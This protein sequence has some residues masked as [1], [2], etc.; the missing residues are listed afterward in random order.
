MLASGLEV[1]TALALGVIGCAG[2]AVAM[3]LRAGPGRIMRQ[4]A[5]PPPAVSQAAEQ[6]VFLFEAGALLDAT[7]KARALLSAGDARTPEQ[8][9]LLTLLAPL[10]PDLPERFHDTAG[11]ARLRAVEGAAAS[12]LPLSAAEVEHLDGRVRLT[13]VDTLPDAPDH[14]LT[15][16]ALRDEMGVLARM[17]AD[18]QCLVWCETPSGSI[19]WANAAYLAF[20]DAWEAT[21]PAG[22]DAPTWP[23]A[24][25]FPPLSGSGPD[26]AAVAAPEVKR[27]L[28]VTDAAGRITGWFDVRSVRRGFETMH[29][30]T[31]ARA[32][33][34][35]EEQGRMFVQT[36]TETFA[37]LSIGLA[38]FD[39]ERRLSTF[40]PALLDLTRLPMTF[41]SGRPTLA[42]TL[43]KLREV[44]VLQE[45]R[46]YR[47]WKRDITALVDA[48]REGTY[49]ETWT[50]A[51]GQTYRVTGRPH[52][53]GAIAFL[54]EDISAEVS[55]TRAF[56]AEIGTAQAVLD[57]LD[58]A[59]AV[60][61]P[62]GT[63][64][65]C[66][67]RF[68]AIWLPGGDAGRIEPVTLAQVVPLWQ[69]RAAPT[70]FWAR[71]RGFVAGSEGR[72]T[73]TET[74]RLTDGRA[75]ICRLTPLPGGATL[76]AFADG[77][78]AEVPLSGIGA[79][80]TKA[81]I[82]KRLASALP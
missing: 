18:T 28:K 46:D 63:L 67:A 12:A 73:L 80:E 66:N 31:D 59:I 25:V 65:T 1:W 5:A 24:T 75:A 77:T 21:E 22:D 76:V 13:L 51:G 36:M 23:P 20:A 33:V 38:I 44:G 43:D 69:A 47:S 14:P 62:S 4:G 71:L 60:F 2:L 34:A 64:T 10:F 8:E 29:F 32:L 41:L 27:R 15:I 30:A 57:T 45:P 39:R 35:A 79:Q 17:S 7:P 68:E 52:P 58:A 56:R 61:S 9:R 3:M 54:F 55:L 19:T 70:P 53:N 11:H 74:L 37:Q 16:A 26:D 48:A 78:G 42:A 49:C 82:G 72:S 81:A 6:A 40:N 50:L